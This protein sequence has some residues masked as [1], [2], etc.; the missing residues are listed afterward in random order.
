MIEGMRRVGVS[1]EAGIPPLEMQRIA[2]SNA[3][4]AL[5]LDARIGSVE[6]GKEADLVLLAADPA[7]PGQQPRDHRGHPRR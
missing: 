1:V 2:T 7:R 3:A 6:V 5:G 4:R